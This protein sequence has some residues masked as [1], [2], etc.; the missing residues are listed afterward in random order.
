MMEL[1][2]EKTSAGNKR[3]NAVSQP[4]NKRMAS[5]LMGHFKLEGSPKWNNFT[6]RKLAL[7]KSTRRTARN[8]MVSFLHLLDYKLSHYG[9]INF[10]QVFSNY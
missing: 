2:P 7:P 1:T 10:T 5:Q 3:A 8:V 9:N 6:R 4:A